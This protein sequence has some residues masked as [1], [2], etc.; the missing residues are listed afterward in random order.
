MSASWNM[1]KGVGSRYVFINGVM[2]GQICEYLA[3]SSSASPQL[4]PPTYPGKRQVHHFHEQ[5]RRSK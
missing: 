4:A 2:D 5:D 3:V 1:S